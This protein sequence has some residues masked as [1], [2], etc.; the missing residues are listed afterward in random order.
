[1]DRVIFYEL[2]GEKHPLVFTFGVSEYVDEKYDGFSKFAK[3]I[4]KSATEALKAFVLLNQQGCA[5]M[6]KKYRDMPPEPGAH[7]VK[8]LYT[9]LTQE[10]LELELDPLARV[11]IVTAIVDAFKASTETRIKGI[12]LK[13]A[14][15]GQGAEI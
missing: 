12:D 2:N 6:N 3:A 13:K 11:D 10:E 7:I 15:A 1:M 5:Y 8:G 4:D 14:E 9:P